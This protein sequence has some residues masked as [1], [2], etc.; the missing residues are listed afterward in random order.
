[1]CCTVVPMDTA[2]WL[3]APT[4]VSGSLLKKAVRLGSLRGMPCIGTC[5]YPGAHSAARMLSAQSEKCF[6]NCPPACYLCR[7]RSEP[8]GIWPLVGS[9]RSRSDGMRRDA[10]LGEESALNRQS[11]DPNCAN[12]LTSLSLSSFIWSIGAKLN[13]LFHPLEMILKPVA[14]VCTP[15]HPYAWCVS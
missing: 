6:R 10:L 13:S 11:R 5:F 15:T 8:S 12:P 3:S 7:P 9:C 4:P 1:M 14:C 2:C